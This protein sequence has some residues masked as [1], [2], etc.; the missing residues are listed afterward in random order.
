MPGPPRRRILAFLI[1]TGAEYLRALTVAG[2]GIEEAARQITFSISI[3]C[4][5]YQGISK[6]RAARL[7]WA[8]VVAACGGGEEAQRLRLRTTTARRVLTTRTPMINILRNTAAAYAGAVG[9]ADAI[10][11]VPIEAPDILGVAASRSNARNTQLIIAEE[12]H[13][14]HV[15][16]PAGGAWYIEWYTRQL[17]GRAWELFREIEA[18]GGMIAAATEGWAVRRIDVVQAKR[19]RDIATRRFPITGVSE[20]AN[21]AEGARGARPPAA[22]EPLRAAAS[23]RLAAWRAG[24]AAADGLAALAQAAGGAGTLTARAIEAAAAG[25]TIGQLA[26]ALVPEGGAPARVTPLPVNPFDQAY[27]HL[28][29][30][31]D[32]FEAKH[33][34]RPRVC[35]AGFGS[36]AQQIGRKTF[37]SNFFQAG[38]FEVLAQEGKF[39]IDQA[40]AAFAASGARIA[41]ICSTDKLYAT[42]VAELA[43]KLKA[44]GARTVILA[45]H[46]GAEEAAYREA[47]VDDFI[48]LK[49]D[50]LA[51]LTS[52]LRE[53]GAL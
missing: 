14:N 22:T 27:D 17:A 43:P 8:Q 6:I 11:T 52:L 16:D 1:A 25:A 47:G 34:H 38:G 4:R 48:F 36:I 5:F 31:A 50:V 26:T 9:G 21:A 53:E 40:V 39:D 35:L 3:G 7:L 24:H 2:L 45:G 23:T 15:I 19:E 49:A 30:A 18:E 29:D 33:G 10:T 32:A 51:T 46:P 13:L 12:C 41:V 20:H 42:G 44:A 28:R 37:A